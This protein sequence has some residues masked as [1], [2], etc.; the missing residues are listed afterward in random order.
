MLIDALM[1]WTNGYTASGKMEQVWSF[2]GQPGGG[3]ILNVE[4]LEE[5]D[6]I[7]SAF[8]FAPFSEINVIPLVD[9]EQSMRHLRN[10]ISAMTP[11][12]R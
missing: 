3:G 7:M 10:A 8:P 9:L 4:S 6:E 1:A 11:P 2:G 5:L 12:G